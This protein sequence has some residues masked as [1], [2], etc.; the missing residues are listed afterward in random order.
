MVL[1]RRQK[2]KPKKKSNFSE[3][4]SSFEREI[5]IFKESEMNFA[6]FESIWFPS[7]YNSCRVLLNLRVSDANLAPVESISLSSLYSQIKMFVSV[8]IYKT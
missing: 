1:V 2:K 4:R 6:P 8:N 7:K 3:L 5:F